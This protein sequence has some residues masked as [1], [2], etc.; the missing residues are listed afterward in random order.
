M[1]PH[2]ISKESMTTGRS[3]LG[4]TLILSTAS[5][6]L[7]SAQGGPQKT[8]APPSA[9]TPTLEDQLLSH[10]PADWRPIALRYH[11]LTD[12]FQALLKIPDASELDDA[13]RVETMQ[14][15][16]DEAGAE[17]FVVAHLDEII[18][19]TR[20]EGDEQAAVE[21]KFLTGFLYQVAEGDHWLHSP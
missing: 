20:S 6:L 4:R 17:E 16:I 1:W 15:L 19:A 11:V 3:L 12:S 2:S 13:V 10:L 21:A 9:V 14:R 5:V 18:A 7:L 8:A